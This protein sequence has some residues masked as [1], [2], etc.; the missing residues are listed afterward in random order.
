VPSVSLLIPAYNEHASIADVIERSLAVL[1][2]CTTDAELI[3]LDDASKDDTFALMQQAKERHPDIRIERHTVN[4]GIAK[5]FEDLYKMASKDFLFLI[6]GDGQFPPE[7][8]KKCMPLL[9]TNDVVICDRIYKDYTLYRHIISFSYRWFPRILFG[10]DLRDPGTIKCV[11]RE[12]IKDIQVTSTS[13]FVEAERFIR[14]AKRGYK[15][16]H[17][18]MIQ[19]QRK[20]GKARGGKPSTIAKSVADM[21]RVWWSLEVLRQKA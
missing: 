20:G 15:I 11:R 19:E 3:V 13:V 17:V 7:T 9:E 14:A 10:V 5:T 6:S 2:E 16:A 21:M 18:D 4:G 12:I 8:L 1:K